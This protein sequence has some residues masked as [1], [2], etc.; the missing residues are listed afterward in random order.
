MYNRWLPRLS[1]LALVAI[2]QWVP[3]EALLG[4]IL[5]LPKKLRLNVETMLKNG[6]RELVLLRSPFGTSMRSHYIIDSDCSELPTRSSSAEISRLKIPSGS[7]DN[8]FIIV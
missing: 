7:F 5:Q 3:N 4:G 8:I 6:R 1:D 2:Q